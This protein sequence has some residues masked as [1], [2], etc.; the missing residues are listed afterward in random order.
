MVPSIFKT[1]EA[2][3]AAWAARFIFR[4]IVGIGRK[5]A[6]S[7]FVS[8]SLTQN[9]VRTTLF[10]RVMFATD[11]ASI[12]MI[13][14]ELANAAENFNIENP[15]AAKPT[16]WLKDGENPFSISG[17]NLIEKNI[18]DTINLFIVEYDTG[19]VFGQIDAPIQVKKGTDIFLLSGFFI[20]GLPPKIP[21]GTVVKIIGEFKNSPNV[22]IDDSPPII[23]GDSNSVQFNDDVG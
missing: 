10:N 18:R 1:A 21:I 3:P 22:I 6:A 5:R 15:E 9:T 12:Y 2:N 19:H 23:V 14:S 17:Q 8:R 11:V 16:I 4:F 13:G 20:D 7:T